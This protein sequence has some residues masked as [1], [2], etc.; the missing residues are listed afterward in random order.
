MHRPRILT[1]AGV[2]LAAATVGFLSIGLW[3]PHGGSDANASVASAANL[4]TADSIDE[5]QNAT[6]RA[7][8]FQRILT[9]PA[10]VAG[11]L[12]ANAPITKL[13]DI[14]AG[15]V[16]AGHGVWVAGSPG[17]WQCVKALDGTGCALLSKS[18]P[19]AAFSVSH[20]VAAGMPSIMIG[21][22]IPEVVSFSVE[23]AS[24][25]V[26]PTMIP[27]KGFVAT[28]PYPAFEHCGLTTTTLTD[29]TVIKQ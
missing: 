8:A 27:G 13:F 5:V 1:L 2:L 9:D 14:P 20:P 29:G 24:G 10:K 19:V 17:G 6:S 11:D 21:W 4:P 16:F 7:A 18:N 25:T 23:C 15:S 26:T 28:A 22:T 12:T 3:N